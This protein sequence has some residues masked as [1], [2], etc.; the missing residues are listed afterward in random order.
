ML[1][2]FFFFLIFPATISGCQFALVRKI[3]ADLWHK[4]AIEESVALQTYFQ[5]AKLQR[6]DSSIWNTITRRTAIK[7]ERKYRLTAPPDIRVST[8]IQGVAAAGTIWVASIS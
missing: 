1:H 7:A 4:D 6:G 8:D 5:L 2:F 3:D